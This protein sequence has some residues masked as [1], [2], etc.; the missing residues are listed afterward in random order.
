MKRTEEN[1]DRLSDIREELE[2]QLSHLHKQAQAA[3]KYTELK[4]EE[5]LK[6]AQLNALKWKVLDQQ[7]ADKTAKVR[8]FELELEELLYARTSNEAKSE[9]L[10]I[11]Q[12]DSSEAFN[13]VQAR[14]YESGAEIA[15]VEQSLQ[16]QKER[17]LQLGERTS[18]SRL[19]S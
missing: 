9:Q 1:L 12:H 2:R 10:R 7:V 18:G 3:E 15:R 6:N 4:K 14:Y 17:A 11:E 19:F 5:R 13:A 8:A 16:H